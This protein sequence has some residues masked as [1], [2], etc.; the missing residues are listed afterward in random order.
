MKRLKKLRTAALTGFAAILLSASG[1]YAQQQQQQQQQPLP[2]GQAPA[3]K[4]DFSDETLE[5]FIDINKKLAPHQQQGEAEMVKAIEGQGLETERFGE[6]MTARQMNDSTNA[7][8]SEEELKK[9][10]SA[11]QEIMGIQQE[12]QQ[13][14]TKVIVDEGMELQEFEDIILA[15]QYS[16]KVQKKINELV[17]QDQAAGLA[18]AD[19]SE[20]TP[21]E[22]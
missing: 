16:P 1:L 22:E 12:L 2:G 10:E 13:K 18:P 3:V 8:A 5:K 9:V 7:G 19:S 17:Q 20:A 21:A 4:E 11:T 14:M 6:I 15:Y